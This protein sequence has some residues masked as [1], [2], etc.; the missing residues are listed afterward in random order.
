MSQAN[1]LIRQQVA[2][3]EKDGIFA[4]LSLGITATHNVVGNY[5]PRS[6]DNPNF[7]RSFETVAHA[8]SAFNENLA[9]TR[10]RGW[11]VIYNGPP[12]RG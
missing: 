10:D 5:D 8:E 9:T 2:I 4:C 1:T 6:K 3:V 12:L 11:T 7:Y